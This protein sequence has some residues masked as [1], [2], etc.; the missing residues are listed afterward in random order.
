MTRKLSIETTFLVATI[1]I[2]VKND[3]IDGNETRD[4]LY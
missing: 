3:L 1:L 2:S 4:K